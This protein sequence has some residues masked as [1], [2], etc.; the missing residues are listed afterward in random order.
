ME[1]QSRQDAHHAKIPIRK[2]MIKM[3]CK[4]LTIIQYFTEFT[5]PVNFDNF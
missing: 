3:L 2:T 5:P 4:Q 1:K